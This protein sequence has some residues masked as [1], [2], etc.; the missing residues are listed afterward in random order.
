MS[1]NM[2]L[3]IKKNPFIRGMVRIIDMGCV[4]DK[5]FYISELKISEW[6]KISLDWIKVGKDISNSIENYH[7]QF[8]HVA[9]R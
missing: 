3:L 8:A 1:E 5:S 6:D 9:Q 2:K 7:N 4:I